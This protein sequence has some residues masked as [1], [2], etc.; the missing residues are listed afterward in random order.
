MDNPGWS[1]MV[2]VIDHEAVEIEQLVWSQRSS[3]ALLQ[4]I[5]AVAAFSS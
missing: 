1:L 4:T 3:R 2:G 5:I